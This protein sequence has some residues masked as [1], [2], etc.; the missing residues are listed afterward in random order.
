VL[1]PFSQHVHRTAFCDLALEPCQKLESCGTFSFDAK[2][3]KYFWLSGL[4]EGEQFVNVNGMV[5]VIFLWI[6]MSSARNSSSLGSTGLYL[7][8]K[9]CS[10]PCR[11][12]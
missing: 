3:G 2:L 7:V 9:S 11:T 8:A 12:E 6:R 5:A 4:Q 1:Y 10:L